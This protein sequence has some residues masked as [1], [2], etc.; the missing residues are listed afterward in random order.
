MIHRAVQEY[1]VTQVDP[2]LQTEQYITENPEYGKRKGF[3]DIIEN[4][5]NNNVNI[6]ELKPISY[7]IPPKLLLQLNQIDRYREIFA[8]NGIN[9]NGGGT[10]T[11]NGRSLQGAFTY[12]NP[13]ATIKKIAKG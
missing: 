6:W 7:M 5:D 9:A 11:R 13:I 10:I 1:I 4:I 2:N 12:I 3:V 8:S